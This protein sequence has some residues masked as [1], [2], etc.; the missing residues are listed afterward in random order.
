M[1]HGE[2]AKRKKLA[3]R[4]RVLEWIAKN[5]DNKAQCS[6][7]LGLSKLTVYRHFAEIEK[8]QEQCKN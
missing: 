3:N 7:D 5:G 4:Q 1:K 2:Y 6:R 8:E